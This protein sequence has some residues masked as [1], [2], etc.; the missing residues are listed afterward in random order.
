MTYDP[1]DADRGPAAGCMTIYGRPDDFS[2]LSRHLLRD[3]NMQP[4]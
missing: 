3:K 4:R 2:T 1:L